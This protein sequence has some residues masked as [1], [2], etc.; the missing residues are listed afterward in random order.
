[1]ENMSN[2]VLLAVIEACGEALVNRKVHEE[3]LM[4]YIDH[5]EKQVELLCKEVREL[6][7]VDEEAVRKE[8]EK[9]EKASE[10]SDCCTAFG[11]CDCDTCDG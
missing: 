2:N 5:K 11:G 4:K 9:I 3:R 7:G 1:M 6:K 8:C 10:T